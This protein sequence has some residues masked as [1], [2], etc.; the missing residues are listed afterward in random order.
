MP[1]DMG[2][3][4]DVN[5]MDEAAAHQQW[6]PCVPRVCRPMRKFI[7]VTWQGRGVAFTKDAAG[8]MA[9]VLPV[10]VAR[11]PT[12]A[13]AADR[14][15]H[16]PP[17]TAAAG[18]S[19]PASSCPYIS[20]RLAPGGC[21]RRWRCSA[22]ATTHPSHSIGKWWG[23]RHSGGARSPWCCRRGRCRTSGVATWW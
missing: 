22:G 11:L 2:R 8:P 4:L 21:R 5:F 16:S 14:S 1:A 17:Q 12:P 3:R 6:C 7:P 23:R 15:A 10:A 18:S 13:V 9:I 19:A 20:F